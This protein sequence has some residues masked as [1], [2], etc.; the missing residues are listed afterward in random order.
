[1]LTNNNN[2]N[3]KIHVTITMNAETDPIESY[4]L[5]PE[6]FTGFNLVQLI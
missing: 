4:F 5:S 2:N 1:M 6:K 3:K